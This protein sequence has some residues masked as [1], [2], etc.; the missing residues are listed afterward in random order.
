MS[1]TSMPDDA[2][3]VAE[4]GHRFDVVREI[5]AAAIGGLGERE[6]QPL[7]FDHLVVVPLRPAGQPVGGDAREE[8][9]RRGLRDQPRRRQV[10]LRLETLVA[11]PSQPG[12]ERERRAQRQAA[13][14]DRAIGADQEG[15][16]AQEPGGDA[17]ERAPF[18]DRFQ[19]AIEP[20]ALQRA[21]A[22]RARSSGG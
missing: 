13:A 6:R 5:R 18:A 19:R 20:A 22:R 16:R 15:Q 4:C 11:P 17:G 12:V 1:R 21:Q 3:S 14:R 7:R 10:Q 8:P 2:R 9:Q